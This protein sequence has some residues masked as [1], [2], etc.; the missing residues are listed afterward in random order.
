VISSNSK[1]TRATNKTLSSSIRK[2]GTSSSASNLGATSVGLGV[3]EM[4]M[5]LKLPKFPFIIGALET[6]LQTQ[7]DANNNLNLSSRYDELLFGSNN[8]ATGNVSH[9]IGSNDNSEFQSGLPRVNYSSHAN[10]IP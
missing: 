9:G 4:P 2:N 10:I 5:Q 3:T 1:P 7:M 8:S 6:S